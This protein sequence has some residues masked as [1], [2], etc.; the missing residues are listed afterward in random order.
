[1]S[2][3]LSAHQ[4][5]RLKEFCQQ[6]HFFHPLAAH[7]LQTYWGILSHWQQ[8]NNLC[9]WTDFDDWLTLG[10][11]DAYGIMTH[12]K[13]GDCLLDVGSGSGLPGMVI[14]C[15]FDGITVVSV[16]RRS[17]RAAFLRAASHACACPLAVERADVK[18]IHSSFD[19]ITARGVAPP[20]ELISLTKHCS[21]EMTRWVCPQTPV[22]VEKKGEWKQWSY[23]DREYHWWVSDVYK[24]NKRD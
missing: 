9:G 18:D 10:V 3:S 4:C 14:A 8:K 2:Q 17:K 20:D 16:E 12:L 21:T 13:R 1:M 6:A 23:A 24:K 19:I 15:C 22:E 11:F 7:R 5:N